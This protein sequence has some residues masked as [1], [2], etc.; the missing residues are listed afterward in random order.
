MPAGGRACGVSD[1]ANPGEAK[2]DIKFHH[3][4]L[5]FD[6]ANLKNFAPCNRPLNCRPCGIWLWPAG[7]LA[8]WLACEL[9]F[10]ATLTL[11]DCLTF[12][13][14]GWLP[15]V[16]PAGWGDPVGTIQ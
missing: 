1:S 5:P 12:L 4:L 6:V 11:H 3:A 2:S 9:E 8:F 13:V 14:A 15:A 7:W 16:Q 10:A